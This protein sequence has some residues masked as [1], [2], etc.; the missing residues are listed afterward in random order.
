MV[1]L[2]LLDGRGVANGEEGLFLEELEH[3]GC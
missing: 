1:A 3:H 2:N